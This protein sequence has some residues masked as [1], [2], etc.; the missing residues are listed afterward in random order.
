MTLISARIGRFEVSANVDTH[1]TLGW[2][3]CTLAGFPGDPVAPRPYGGSRCLP[4]AM[5]DLEADPRWLCA[6]ELDQS[7]RLFCSHDLFQCSDQDG[8]AAFA[9]EILRR[10]AQQPSLL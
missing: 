2:R 5:V 8:A 7:L 6:M 1:A 3:F 4:L 9:R 10:H